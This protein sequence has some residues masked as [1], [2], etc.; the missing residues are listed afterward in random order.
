[1]TKKIIIKNNVI[2][3]S[4]RFIGEEKDI[5]KQKKYLFP[6]IKEEEEEMEKNHGPVAN[7]QRLVCPACKNCIG[8]TY[9]IRH[10]KG[11]I[12]R[13][14]EGGAHSQFLI[15]FQKMKKVIHVFKTAMKM[16]GPVD[17]N[18]TKD[19]TLSSI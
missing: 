5:D 4:G 9:L 16:M 18:L 7:Q 6:I 1:M 11:E 19:Y 3:S 14:K 2:G 10:V 12:K 13:E 15:D 17:M 8:Q